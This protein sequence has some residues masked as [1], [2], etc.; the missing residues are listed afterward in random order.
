MENLVSINMYKGLLN[1]MTV[2][3]ESIMDQVQSAILEQ[4][5]L[6]NWNEK[7]EY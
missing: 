1:V 3:R 4:I 6:R 2:P 5:W 7:W